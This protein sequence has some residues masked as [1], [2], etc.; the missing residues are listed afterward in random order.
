MFENQ[1]KTSHLNSIFLLLK[2]V[3]NDSIFHCNFWCQNSKLH[4]RK[5]RLLFMISKHF[6]KGF[7]VKM[8]SVVFTRQSFC[9]L[10]FSILTGWFSVFKRPEIWGTGIPWDRCRLALWVAAKRIESVLS[11]TAVSERHDQFA[12]CHPADVRPRTAI[13][14]LQSEPSFFELQAAAG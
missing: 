8:M 5:T 7:R 12:N 6:A 4:Y 9:K 10:Q 14:K 1:Q 13:L 11:S 2:N 3:K